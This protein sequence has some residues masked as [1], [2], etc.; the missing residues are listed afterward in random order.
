MQI[1]ELET[2]VEPCPFCGAEA[3]VKTDRTPYCSKMTEHYW[4]KCS[5][6]DCAVSPTSHPSLEAAITR[7][8]SR[9]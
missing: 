6:M 3:I 4:V 9:A 2:E 8:N 7:W 5:N 1:V